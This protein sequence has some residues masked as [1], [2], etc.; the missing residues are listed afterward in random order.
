MRL[1]VVGPHRTTHCRWPLAAFDSVDVI[2]DGQG[3]GL[4][5]EPGHLIRSAGLAACCVMTATAEV[6]SR[7]AEVHQQ[8]KGQGQRLD[9][10]LPLTI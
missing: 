3:C 5:E 9:M 1:I 6:I 4:E 7:G 2:E 8:G 10:E